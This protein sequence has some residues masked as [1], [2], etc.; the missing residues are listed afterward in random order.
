M[1]ARESVYKN[2]SNNAENIVDK[3]SKND[4]EKKMMKIKINA[5]NSVTKKIAK[6]TLERTQRIT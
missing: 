6:K 3:N 5:K 2:F 1:N 4:W